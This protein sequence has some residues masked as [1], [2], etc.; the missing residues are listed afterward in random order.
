MTKLVLKSN[1]DNTRSEIDLK[2][3]KE[4]LLVQKEYSDTI[5]CGRGR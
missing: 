5:E 1:W 3:L 4:N 2:E